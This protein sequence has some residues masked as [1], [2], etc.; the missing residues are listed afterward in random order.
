MLPILS[1]DLCQSTGIGGKAAALLALGDLAPVPPWLVLRTDCFAD[2][3]L[4]ETCR[5]ALPAALASLGPGPYAVRSSGGLEDGGSAA[6]AGQYL[7]LLG[8]AADAVAVA[9]VQ[10]WRSGFADHVAEYQRHHGVAGADQGIAVIVQCQITPL[11]AGVAFAADPVSGARDRMVISTVAGLADRLMSGEVDGDTIQIDANSFAVLDQ[12][13]AGTAPV[14]N[15]GQIA[16]IG[17]LVRRCSQRAGRPQDVEWAIGPDHTLFLLQSRP[18]TKLPPPPDDHLT[19]WDN[20]N[21]IESYPGWTS[22]LTYSFARNV[23]GPVYRRL[24]GLLGVPA[25]IIADHR[26]VLDN[27]LG[28]IDGRIYYNLLNWY[29]LVALLPGFALNRAA[30]E[31]MMGVAEAL[32]PDIADRLAPP[33]PRGWR[34]AL[35]RW[36][37]LRVGVGLIY[38]AVEL[39]WRLRIF[40]R[41]LDRALA[42]PAGPD[43]SL[44]ALAADYRALEAALLDRWDAPLVNDLL[45]MI[46]FSLSRRLLERWAGQPGLLLHAEVMIGQGDIVSAEPA[47]RVRALGRLAAGNPAA[48][49]ALRAGDRVALR[50]FPALQAG[51]D[52]YLERFGDRC[53][54]ELK[55]EN[56]PLTDDPTPLL[57]AIAAAA[58]AGPTTAPPPR[59]VPGALFRDR[60]I[61]RWL[62]MAVLHWAKARVRDR[63]NLRLDRTRLFGRVRRIL[64]AIGDHLAAAGQLEHPQDIFALTIDEVLGAIEGGGIDSDLRQRAAQRLA[65]G[66]LERDL[67]DPPERL[68]FRGAVLLRQQQPSAPPSPVSGEDRRRQGV[69]CAPGQ[70]RAR[71]AVIHDPRRDLVAPGEILVASHTDPGWIALFAN[72]AAIIVER[73]SLL[74]HSAIVA[75]ELGIPCIVGLKGATS[76]LAKGMMVTMDGASGWVERQDD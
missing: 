55:L 64:R 7:S 53:A 24:L 50:R 44:S 29:R 34:R 9:A 15:A 62:A 69:A 74:S 42:R 12:R 56:T 21:I 37:Q 54:G 75:R 40:R 39:P 52:S 30:M 16:A 59:Q 48:L 60:P 27:L 2:D 6:H 25:G 47:Q 3:G 1:R 36:Q 76:W 22:V 4:T 17:A 8:I 68:A 45:C 11:C 33:P 58:E 51:L 70:V 65:Q 19:L 73:G 72:A 63:E 20:S 5:A 26:S 46:G 41:R 61:R 18:I 43:L 35:A 38:R 32:P 10:V 66:A 67:P 71:V 49:A 13:L 31:Q 14:L 28:R 57:A 23:Y